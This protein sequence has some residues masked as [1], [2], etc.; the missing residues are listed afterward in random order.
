VYFIGKGVDGE[1]LMAISIRVP[2][3]NNN[4]IEWQE[5]RQQARQ[6]AQMRL[7]M[8]FGLGL[9]VVSIGTIALTLGNINIPTQ[10]LAVYVIWIV[11]AVT[12]SRAISAGANAISREHVGKTWDSLVLTGINARQILI[13]KWLG[14]LNRVSGWMM[15][16]GAVRLAMLPIFLLS[17]IYRYAWYSGASVSQ[18]Y[19][20]RVVETVGWVPWAAILAVVMSVGLSVL[21]VLTCT[22]LGMATGA[23]ARRGWIAMIAAFCI[24]LV[25]VALFAGFT[26][27]ELGGGPYWRVL[28]FPALSLADAGTGPLWQLALPLTGWTRGEHVSALPGLVMATLLLALILVASLMATWWAIRRDGALAKGRA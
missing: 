23:W 14:V 17:L 6:S 1:S 13:G 21:E 26:R 28:S 3:L 11:H 15:I 22:A 20:D 5:T 9:L 4:P 12:A 10:Q 2:S 19:G 7:S 18:Y 27:Y 16:F 25:P 8:W 24:R